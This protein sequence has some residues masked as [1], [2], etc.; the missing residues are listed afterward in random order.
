MQLGQLHGKNHAISYAL[1]QTGIPLHLRALRSST[2]KCWMTVWSS[3]HHQSPLPHPLTFLKS[4]HFGM[5][6]SSEQD[7]ATAWLII[8]EGFE[9]LVTQQVYFLPA[10]DAS[11]E[12]L[13]Q[14]PSAAAG[15]NLQNWLFY[16]FVYKK[17]TD[18]PMTF[19][20][21]FFV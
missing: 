13:L 12:S 9:Q 15:R 1:N 20:V 17:Q 16:I 4:T 2:G 10:P 7:S 18:K 3:A 14:Y 19:C 21:C 6:P 5:W 11:L 8:N